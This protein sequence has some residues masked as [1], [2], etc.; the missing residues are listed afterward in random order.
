[1]EKGNYGYIDHYK[2]NKLTVAAV[3][4]AL[5]AI[6]IIAVLVIFQTK[7]T[8][9]IV[10]PILLVLPFAKYFVAFIVVQP[11]VTM[12]EES[13]ERV[14]KVVEGN[15]HI[16]PIYDVTLASEAGISYLD[17]IL[18]IDGV[19]YGCAS[20]SN[21][22][23]KTSDMETYLQKLIKGAGYQNKAFV[24]EGVEDTLRAVNKRV[25]SIPENHSYNDKSSRSIKKAILVVGV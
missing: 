12:A 11:Y 22:K 2:K 7:N 10:I 4:L 5:I 18:V 1:M 15:E 9:F 16:I 13:H 14:C 21:K 17:F 23:F 24:Y 6:A 20:H 19:V 3:F 8:Y 25:K